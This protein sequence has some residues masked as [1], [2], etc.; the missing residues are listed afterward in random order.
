L[1]RQRNAIKR[2]CLELLAGRRKRKST[3]FCFCGAEKEKKG[4][5]IKN[6]LGAQTFDF[7]KENSFFEN[8]LRNFFKN[9]R[10]KTCISK[11]IGI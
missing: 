9:F 10:K 3:W 5:K 1:G 4:K 2:A 6:F 8:F 7:T 11:N